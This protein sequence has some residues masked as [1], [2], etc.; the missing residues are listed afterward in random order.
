MIPDSAQ[1]RLARIGS[2]IRARRGGARRAIRARVPACCASPRRCAECSASRP[3]KLL[4]LAVPLLWAAALA[5][6]A[7]AIYSKHRARE[8]FVELER[9][10]VRAR[11]PGDRMGPAA[12]RAER[13]VDARLRR[14]R[15]R[16]QA[17]DGDAA[18]ERHRAGVA[19]KACHESF[20]R[21]APRRARP[22]QRRARRHARRSAQLSLAREL[23]A[24]AAGVRRARAG[25]ARGRAA[26]QGSQVPR[27][28]GRRAL[29]A[30]RGDHRDARHDH[31]SLRRA[32]RGVDAGRFGVGE[33]EGAGARQRS[34]AAAGESAEAR[35]ERARAAR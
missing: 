31:R 20:L 11:Q 21:Q 18:A 13:L 12:A 14:E 3:N 24:G 33:S 32:A 1:P 29:F 34:A 2:K 35:Q 30:G 6:A 7:G 26:A 4:L 10:N 22:R 8:L 15:G 16:H 27:R 17:Q 5:S 19:V 25:V 28:P 23:R 9:L